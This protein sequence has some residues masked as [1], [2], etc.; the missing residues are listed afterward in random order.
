MPVRH[1]THDD[2]A[3]P[4]RHTVDTMRAFAHNVSVAGIQLAADGKWKNRCSSTRTERSISI[5]S[6]DGWRTGRSRD[7]AGEALFVDDSQE[8]IG[9]LGVRA[10]ISPG[11]DR[12]RLWRHVAEVSCGDVQIG[13]CSRG[14]SSS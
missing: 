10:T 4:N 3:A 7:V 5:G 6:R 12:T 13:S 1:E 9:F 8:L 14:S 2:R 11:A